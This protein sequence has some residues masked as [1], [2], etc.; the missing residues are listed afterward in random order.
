MMTNHPNPID[1]DSEKTKAFEPSTADDATLLPRADSAPRDEYATLDQSQSGQAVEAPSRPQ[2]IK[3]FG[4]YEILS[5]I[6]RG[7]MGV[8]YKAR[9]SKLNRIVA[10]KMILSGELASQ[11]AISR[12]FTEAQAAA[13]LDH[14]GIVPVYE[15]GE[16][17]GKHYF[18]MGYIEGKS[19][20][21]KVNQGP[22]P[23]KE[24]A[25]MTRKIAEAIAYA[26]NKGVIHRD[27]KPANVLLDANGEPKVSDFGLARKIEQDS[28]LTRTGAVMGTPSYMPPEQAAGKT[29]QVG[30]LSDVYS[31]GAILYCL[32][33]GRPP[34]QAANPLDTMMQVIEKEPVS[35]QTLN[36]GVPKDL[37][38]ICHKCLQ[39]DPAKRYG[40]AQEFADDLQRWLK[41]EP[42]Q[43]RAVSSSERMWR[44]V[45]RNPVVSGSIAAAM[46]AVILGS[47]A[48]LWFGIE[49]NR[50]R[51]VADQKTAEV[52]AEK[53]NV[54][55]QKQ[56]A[57][58]AE[59]NARIES[60]HTR[61]ALEIS[62]LSRAR[63]NNFL[64]SALFI[65]NRA[66]EAWWILQNIPPKYRNLEWFLS[67]KECEGGDVTLHGHCD[68]VTCVAMSPDGS[69][70]VSGS[71]DSTLKLWNAVSGEQLKTFVGHTD[72]ITSVAFTSDGTRIVSGSLDNSIKIWDPQ[73]GQET[74][75]LTGHNDSVTSVAFSS[76]GE[77]I[78]SGSRDTTIKV[79]N[80]SSG[81][82]ER[83]LAGHLNTV[84][85]VAFSPDG[86]TVASG[87][88]DN[89]IK[90]W[91]SRT[92]QQLKTFTGQS[93]QNCVAFS[94]DGMQIISASDD[95]CVRLF[96]TSSGDEIIVL[97]GHTDS[98]LSVAFSPDGTQIISGGADSTLKLWDPKSGLEKRT[99]KGRFRH[100]TSVTFS[101]D[102]TRIV[103]ANDAQTIKFWDSTTGMDL[104]TLTEHTSPVLR[105]ST[106]RDGQRLISGSE[107]GVLLLWDITTG[108][109]IQRLNGHK[110]AITSV[111]FSPDCKRI[112]SGSTDGTIK[113][114]DASSG[115]LTRTFYSDTDSVSRVVF[116]PDGEFII[117]IEGNTVRTR[118]SITGQLIKTFDKD[119]QY[120]TCLAI[121]PNSLQI[122]IA[123]NDPM[124]ML[125]DAD[126]GQELNSYSHQTKGSI[127]DISI[128]PDSATVAIT[129]P[130][131]LL[132]ADSLKE[133]KSFASNSKA[134]LA[135][136]AV[137]SPDSTRLVSGGFDNHLIFWNTAENDELK[138]V[139]GH[140]GR[141]NAVVFTPDGSQLFSGS[142]DHTIIRWDT[143]KNEEL[144]LLTGHNGKVSHVG[145][146]FDGTRVISAG[147]DE[148][149]KLWDAASGKELRTFRIP[150]NERASNIFFSPDGKFVSAEYGYDKMV[151]DVETG[152]Q[153]D[154]A[155]TT[156]EATLKNHSADGRYLAISIGNN[157]ALVDLEYAKS[158]R[159]QARRKRSARLKPHW[160]QEQAVAA[161]SREDWYAA[162][163]HRAW[164]VRGKPDSIQDRKSLQ[165][166]LAKLTAK[167][168]SLA[169]QFEKLLSAD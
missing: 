76:D 133:L 104:N 117:S 8:V 69:Q 54:E 73:T 42:I 59:V 106:S 159:E 138:L 162:T 33:T 101:P 96:D 142:I 166:S 164:A 53:A 124:L 16:H 122:L 50:S 136:C 29:S 14:P 129:P 7:G 12:F 128:S 57:E 120:L 140:R 108:E 115:E 85:C 99:L 28:G 107:D 48:S 40:S 102:G 13:T 86:A 84:S 92:G 153:V 94:P 65:Q 167:S 56:I 4:D 47:I 116:S 62:E 93:H 123:T 43:A 11:E 126:S 71:W 17:E 143:S 163:F 161:E 130:L 114:W 89:T 44:W 75:T 118:E 135:S 82:E 67:I 15:I 23:P 157:V 10:V 150:R 49:A 20:A 60:E 160:H 119:L 113:I 2:S 88:W 6:A 109:L 100:V 5:E 77:R 45:K 19:L 90:L 41:G 91:N 37:E 147:W 66:E 141:V 55:K 39:K 52:L 103:S 30:P 1:D 35:V 105:L 121:K 111:A 36:S 158:P 31:L 83:T 34:F 9:Q 70:V 79:W 64:S 97:T 98:V 151:W 156:M 144:K 80:F 32:L 134:I 152:A 24:A 139:N 61:E 81:K 165:S 38:T 169:K 26:H 74:R 68:R 132:E 145:F 46:S 58:T 21:E 22:L 127:T 112:V 25:E 110:N 63:S 78:I 18:T 95:N 155:P 125:L 149:V 154:N 148:A 131:T 3:Y 168:P 87:S 51:F 27:L 137:F 72:G 146:N